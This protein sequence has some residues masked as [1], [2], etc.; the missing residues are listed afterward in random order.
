MFMNN[1]YSINV[2]NEVAFYCTID[3]FSEQFVTSKPV[4]QDSMASLDLYFVF[5]VIRA[6]NAASHM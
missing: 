1:I 5:I 3:Q 2:M 4:S 6:E